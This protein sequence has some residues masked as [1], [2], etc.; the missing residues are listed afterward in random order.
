MIF[1]VFVAF[2]VVCSFSDSFFNDFDVFC[3]FFVFCIIFFTNR[4]FFWFFSKPK[5]K[6][7]KLFDSQLNFLIFNRK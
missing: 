7:A 3:R 5:N 6:P 4:C 1:E 2:S